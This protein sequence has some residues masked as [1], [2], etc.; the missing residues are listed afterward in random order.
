MTMDQITE[1]IGLDNM[2][3]DNTDEADR[4]Y[5]EAINFISFGK[6]KN[7]TFSEQKRVRFLF[8]R[9]NEVLEISICRPYSTDGTEPPHSHFDTM[10]Y[11]GV[12]TIF[13][14][15]VDSNG[16]VIIDYYGFESISLIS[17]REV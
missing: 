14:Y 3:T 16:E 4:I 15:L 8:D 12:S 6:D 11:N 2:A 10:D 17:L 7:L 13:D 1:I 9:T 5:I